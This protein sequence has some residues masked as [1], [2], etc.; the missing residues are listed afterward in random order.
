KSFGGKFKII[1]FNGEMIGLCREKILTYQDGICS[2]ATFSFFRK[3]MSHL[4]I[5]PDAGKH[6]REMSIG[7]KSVNW[8]CLAVKDY[9][10]GFQSI[11]WNPCRQR[12]AISRPTW[13]HSKI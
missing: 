6:A 4:C 2:K 8:F 7:E 5:E 9:V 10:Q 1:A 13:D 3:F 12:K 11:F